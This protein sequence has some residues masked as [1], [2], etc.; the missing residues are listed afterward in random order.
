MS[1]ARKDGVIAIKLWSLEKQIEDL[2]KENEQLKKTVK[3]YEDP[4]DLTLMY[5]YCGEKLKEKIEKLQ[6]ENEK[7]N[8][9]YVKNN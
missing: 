5:M 2:Q 1:D 7:L 8:E 6:Q 9:T 4:E 3:T